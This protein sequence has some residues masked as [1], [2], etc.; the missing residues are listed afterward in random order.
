[1][2]KRGLCAALVAFVASVGATGFDGKQFQTNAW[3]KVSVSDNTIVV[4]PGSGTWDTAPVVSANSMEFDTDDGLT[5]TPT[6]PASYTDYETVTATVNS[7]AGDGEPDELDE[8]AQAA[9]TMAVVD[10]N[11]Q[12]MGWTS[13]GWKNLSYTAASTPYASLESL[14]NGN[15]TLYMDFAKENSSRYIRYSVQLAGNA[16]TVL[17]DSTGVSWF[18]TTG[19][20]V[21]S[22]SFAGVGKVKTFSADELDEIVPIT[23]SDVKFTY[24][25]SY[26]T[27]TTVVANV[28]G[29]VKSGTTF[30]LNFGENNYTGDYA[31]DTVTFYNVGGSLN[32]GDNVSYTITASGMATGTTGSQTTTVG[33]TRGDWINENASSSGSGRWDPTISYENNI[34]ALDN[35]TF[36]PTNA[37]GDA[38]VTVVS[39]MSFGD[40]ADASLEVGNSYAA[41]RIGDN[42]G[43]P[44]FQIWAKTAE[45]GNA[46]WVNVAN[47]SVTV[48]PANTYEVKSVFDFVQ[49]KCQ[50]H[51]ND[52]ALA[53]N[54]QTSFYL[55]NDVR[56][57]S[58]VNFNGKGS[59]TSLYGSYVEAEKIVEDISG[60]GVPVDSD[61]VA[62]NLGDKTFAEARTLLAPESTEKTPHAGAEYNYFECY[63]LGID[64]KDDDEAPLV[65]AVPGSDGKFNVSLEGISVPAGVTVTA[66]LKTCDTP[67]GT[68]AGDQT[69]IAVGT[70]AG[71]ERTGSVEFDPAS[72]SGN[73][74]Y[75]KMEIGIGAT[76]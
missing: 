13:S 9:F 32:L 19:E 54:S 29:V 65:V 14:T 67:N 61:W 74:K 50:F 56:K 72:M 20:H 23:F 64:P 24:L 39:T 26:A 3:F 15:F 2:K 68:F 45:N 18:E 31:N 8:N 1:M 48:D 62:D 7:K 49:G 34:A 35:N 40:V 53:N 38:V 42:S 70:E 10:G 44:T 43:T 41:I 21:N 11:L 30:T 12:A 69:A 73:V 37:V 52:Y 47:A 4:N 51:V 27:A 60:T 71:T 17:T 5:F 25:T 66:K 75:I 58:A 33:T 59:L 46:E 55:A 57:M 63:A 6:A 22:I 76:K 28:S 16:P 36:T